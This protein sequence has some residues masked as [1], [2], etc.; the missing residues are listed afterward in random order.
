L[1]RNEQAELLTISFVIPCTENVSAFGRKV[2]KMG[3]PR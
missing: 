3:I 2:V 1:M